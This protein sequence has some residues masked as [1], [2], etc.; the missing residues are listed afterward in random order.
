MI[1]DTAFFSSIDFEKLLLRALPPPFLPEV[2]NEHDTKSVYCTV[3][4]STTEC[5][6][7][8]SLTYIILMVRYVPRAYLQA[9]V[10]D[11]VADRGWLGGG[12]KKSAQQ[13]PNFEAFTYQ[14]P[15]SAFTSET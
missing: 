1:M 7:D 12:G 15:E 13:Q 9:E 10:K 3:L 14:G 5:Y 8:Y 11:S 6:V 2:V 4:C